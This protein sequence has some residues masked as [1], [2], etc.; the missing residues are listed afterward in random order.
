LT[1]DRRELILILQ[2]NKV[3][4]LVIEDLKKDM[5]SAVKQHT[6]IKLHELILLPV[7][8]D[9]NKIKINWWA[10]SEKDSDLF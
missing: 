8:I 1:F 9:L 4:K 5:P 2:G 3:R 7:D 10:S 6:G